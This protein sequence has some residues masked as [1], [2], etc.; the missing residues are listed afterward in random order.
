LRL[1]IL[2]GGKEG[3]RAEQRKSE[4]EFVEPRHNAHKQGLEG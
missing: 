4:Q 1:G 3:Q 2:C